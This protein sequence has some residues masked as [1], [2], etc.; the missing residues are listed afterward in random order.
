MRDQGL[1]FADSLTETNIFDALNEHGFD[2]RDRVFGPVTT[3]WGFPEI[4]HNE[5]QSCRKAV[6]RIIAYP[7]QAASWCLPN[8]AS[9]CN[10]RAGA[11]HWKRRA[12]WPRGTAQQLP[13]RPPRRVEVERAERVYRRRVARLDAGHAGEPGGLPTAG[14]A[15]AGHWFPPGQAHRAALAGKPDSP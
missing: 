5:D 13:G 14:G 6:S 8:T 10:A 11:S 9:Y 12:T 1:P 3:I 7:P 15:G 4:V 2:Y